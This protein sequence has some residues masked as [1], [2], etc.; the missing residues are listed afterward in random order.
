MYAPLSVQT[1]WGYGTSEYFPC[2]CSVPLLF[3]ASINVIVTITK[4]ARSGHDFG[5]KMPFVWVGRFF[6]HGY[7]INCGNAG[8]GGRGYH[9]ANGSSF[10]HTLFLM[11]LAVAIQFLWAHIFLVHGTS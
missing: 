6:T 9:V 10:R 7:S 8:I 11:P 3:L 5:S 4:H 2:I 1:G